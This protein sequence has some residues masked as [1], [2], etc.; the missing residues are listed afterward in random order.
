[1]PSQAIDMTRYHHDQGHSCDRCNK[2]RLCTVN[3]HGTTGR[4]TTYQ[5]KSPS[6]QTYMVVINASGQA[7]CNCMCGQSNYWSTCSHQ[8][9]ARWHDAKY[10]EPFPEEYF[11]SVL[12]QL[13][14]DGD[15]LWA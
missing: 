12:H 11:N 14:A 4:F 3:L 1:M 10:D 7:T 13:E 9:A 8:Q 5:V 15:R 6:G 2:A